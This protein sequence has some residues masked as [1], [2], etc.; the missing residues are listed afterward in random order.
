M[1]IVSS[2]SR[3]SGDFYFVASVETAK[4]E[5]GFFDCEAARPRGRERGEKRAASSLKMTVLGGAVSERDRA[6]S[7]RATLTRRKGA[8]YLLSMT[9]LRGAV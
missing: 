4:G 7:A 9:V 8:A 1:A 3:E 5:E 2:R 6:S